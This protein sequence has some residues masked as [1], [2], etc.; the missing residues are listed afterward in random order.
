MKLPRQE[1]TVLTDEATGMRLVHLHNPG[2][3]AG[4]FGVAVRAGSRDDEPGHFGLAHFVEHTIFKGTARRSSWHIINRMEAVG[5]EL[6]AYTTKEETVVYSIFPNGSAPRAIELIADLT[7]NSRFPQKELDKERE[8]VADEIDSYLDTP[9]EAVFDDFEDLLFAGHPLG[10]NILGDRKSLR[11][12]D[13]AVC[14]AYL[15]RH[16]RPDNM[17]AFYCGMQ[18]AQHILDL[19]SR[20]IDSSGLASCAASIQPGASAVATAE[21]AAP[22]NLSRNIGSHQAHTIVGIPTAGMFAPDRH[23]T[24]LLGNIIGGP[25]MNSLLNVE[26]REKRGL[27]YSVE[28]SISSFTDAGMLGIYFGCDPADTAQCTDITLAVLDGIARGTI[29]T[30]RTLAMAK[31][32]YTGQLVISSGNMESSILSAA[33]STLFRGAPFPAAAAAEAIAAV[34]ADQLREVARRFSTA[35]VLTLGR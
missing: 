16:Y 25:G 30:P 1:F 24:A 5:G 15:K 7:A 35:S 26:L 29:I 18:G 27:V 6:N 8:V 21:A 22:F 10:H 13:T 3:R 31:K 17:V 32:Q 19:L 4:I 12:F 28:S 33:R 14:R 9:S 2:A 20:S 34:G 23:A 11:K